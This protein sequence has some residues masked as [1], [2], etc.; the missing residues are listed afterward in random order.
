MGVAKSRVEMN[1]SDRP[2]FPYLISGIIEKLQRGRRMRPR[3][4]CVC[5]EVILGE[6]L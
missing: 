4:N 3:Q 6:R 5:L 2:K 1:D